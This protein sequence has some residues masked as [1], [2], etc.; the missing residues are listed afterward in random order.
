MGGGHT[1]LSRVVV[2]NRLGE[3]GKKKSHSGEMRPNS[4]EKGSVDGVPLCVYDVVEEDSLSVKSLVTQQSRMRHSTKA[5][6]SSMYSNISF[7]GATYYEYQCFGD[8]IV[9]GDYIVDKSLPALGSGANG[10]VFLGFLVE[11]NVEKNID[12][13]S[14]IPISMQL[15]FRRSSSRAS[16]FRMSTIYSNFGMAAQ[17]TSV[18]E[19]AS[20]DQSA[21]TFK[22]PIEDDGEE[23]GGLL[24]EE[25]PAVVSD[26]KA[27][28]AYEDAKKHRQRKSVISILRKKYKNST[29]KFT[30][31]AIKIVDKPSTGSSKKRNQLTS[32]LNSLRLL[33]NHR[34]IINFLDLI[35]TK[36]EVLVV[37]EL[38]SGGELLKKI[39]TSKG[40]RLPESQMRLYFRDILTALVYCHDRQIVHRDIKP[41]NVLIHRS[42]RDD[43]FCTNR[44]SENKKPSFFKRM[45]SAL[46]GKE[47]EDGKDSFMMNREVCKLIDFGFSEKIEPNRKM[48]GRCGSTHYIAPEIISKSEKKKKGGYGGKCADMWSLGVLLYVSLTGKFPFG[49]KTMHDVYRSAVFSQCRYPSHLS[50]SAKDLLK[51]LLC[52]DPERRATV[53]MV[54]NHPW[55][56]E[57][58]GSFFEDRHPNSNYTSDSLIEKY[59]LEKDIVKELKAMGFKTSGGSRLKALLLTKPNDPICVTYALLHQLEQTELKGKA[60]DKAVSSLS[61][62]YRR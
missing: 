31:V 4:G 40:G 52:V 58:M 50:L 30:K 20:T 18:S 23:I 47:E 7:E 51:R 32:E 9:I 38:I 22:F 54:I 29:T 21:D 17:P 55:V 27:Y 16:G 37:T 26:F 5:S 45:L 1:A 3:S 56:N 44:Y 43:V 11:R 14:S 49:G 46:C 12:V 62:K 8:I 61:G 57:K 60:L 53:D 41:E 33:K 2:N 28:R 13:R 15:N 19:E 35:E 42:S 34:N 25:I 36:N 10:D 24:K 59:G 48:N 6:I 39:Q